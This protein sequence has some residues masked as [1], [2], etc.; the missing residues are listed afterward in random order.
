[1]APSNRSASSPAAGGVR[2]GV[3]VSL[4]SIATYFLGQ[5]VPAEIMPDAQ[6]L[7]TVVIAGGIAT[8]GKIARE[9]GSW[10]GEL[11]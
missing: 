3:G 10:V 11:V 2:A 8:V 4:A 6:A 9:R 7:V 1:M 5:V